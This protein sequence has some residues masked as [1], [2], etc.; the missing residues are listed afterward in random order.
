MTVAQLQTHM[1]RRFTRLERRMNACLGGVGGRF[2][3][4]DARFDSMSRAMTEQFSEM[5]R[6]LDSLGDK[7]DTLARGSMCA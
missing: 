1:N 7:L 4:V 3:S 6:R 5:E 2:D